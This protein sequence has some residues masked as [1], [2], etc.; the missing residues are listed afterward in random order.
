LSLLGLADEVA[1]PH[2]SRLSSE[3]RRRL[4]ASEV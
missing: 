1:D 4:E 2:K 3:E